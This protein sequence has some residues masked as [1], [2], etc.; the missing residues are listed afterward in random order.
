MKMRAQITIEYLLAFLALLFCLS[1]LFAASMG[2]LRAA[3]ESTYHL[4]L[5]SSL[6]NSALNL[7]L[8]HLYGQSPNGEI[9]LQSLPTSLENYKISSSGAYAYTL[10]PAKGAAYEYSTNQNPN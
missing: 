2:Y 7:A 9:A 1:I 6:S 10:N 3:K 5:Q 8:F 4:A